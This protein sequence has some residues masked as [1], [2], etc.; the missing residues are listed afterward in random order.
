MVPILL[1]FVL[2]SI[3][4]FFSLSQIYYK[5]SFLHIFAPTTFYY[6]VPLIFH[7]QIQLLTLL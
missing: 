7:C 6:L 2:N 4:K 5:L 3:P 1:L